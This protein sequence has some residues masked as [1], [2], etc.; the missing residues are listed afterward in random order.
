MQE[1]QPTTVILADDHAIVREGFAALCAA[2]G[3]RVLAECSDGCTAVETISM[4][5]PDFAIL[6]LQMP[7]MTGIEVI[8]KLRAAGCPAK[9]II[10]SISRE[11]HTVLEA[12]RAGADGY[13][14]KDG[15]ARHL[16]DA[17][18]FV[19]DGG[20]YV[21]PL[22]RGAVHPDGEEPER[23]FRRKSQPARNGGLLLP[24]E[25]LAPQR[26]RRTAGD[27]S[28]DGRHLSGEPH[29]QVER[30]RLGGLGQVRHRAE[31]Y[32]HVGSARKAITLAPRVAKMRSRQHNFRVR[33]NPGFGAT[34]GVSVRPSETDALEAQPSNPQVSSRLGRCFVFS[35]AS[36][37]VVE[38]DDGLDLVFVINQGDMAADRDVAVVAW[39][40]RQAA[41]QIGRRRVHLPSQTL[42]QHH[43]LM[44]ARFLVGRQSVLVPEPCRRMGLV[45]VVPVA[46]HLLVVLVKLGLTLL[47]LTASLSPV[48]CQSRTAGQG[49]NRGGSRSQ[50]PMCFHKISSLYSASYFSWTFVSRKEELALQPPT[51]VD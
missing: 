45:L 40:R 29:A 9:L 4:L 26:H 46:R 8:R 51:V 36:V 15:P 14:L 48:L 34:A 3:I 5:N 44:Q 23:R 25:R 11:E 21:S 42:V 2:N 6:D 12:L 22:L 50:Q 47:V 28:Q 41:R 38:V 24:G 39:R 18:S 17:M 19:R 32:Q 43:A 7:G 37:V 30:P 31:P 13:L 35:S 1:S 33:R 49:Q 10:L 27:Q 16:L 20:V